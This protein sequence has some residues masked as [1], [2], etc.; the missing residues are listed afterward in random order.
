MSLSFCNEC[1]MVVE[2]DTIDFEC[3]DCGIM[4]EICRHCK[5][6]DVS[7]LAEDDPRQRKERAHG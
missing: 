7:E 1:D 2:G 3:P 4:H 6:S 5:M